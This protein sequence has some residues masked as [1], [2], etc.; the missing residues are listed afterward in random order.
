MI[1]PSIHESE[2]TENIG[3]ST[4]AVA[5][6][7]TYLST[8]VN[9]PAYDIS[10]VFAGQTVRGSITIYIEKKSLVNISEQH[11]STFTH[12]HTCPHYLNSN[13]KMPFF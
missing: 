5:D 9:N 13:F 4:K 1:L 10:Y 7:L 6:D 12:G 2:V 3:V 8:Q 11:L